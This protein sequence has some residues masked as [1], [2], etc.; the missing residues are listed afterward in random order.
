MKNS[1]KLSLLATVIGSL[2][3][4]GCGDAETTII[5]KDPIAVD[6]HDDGHDDHDHGDDIIIESMG[7]LAVLSVES[8][9]ANIFDLDDNSLLDSFTLTYD[10]SSLKVSADYRYATLVNRNDDNVSF[11]DSGL[12]REDHG[13]HLHDYKQIPMVSSFELN[14]S[15]PTHVVNHDGQMAV[16]YDGDADAGTS[17]SVQVLTDTNIANSSSDLPGIEYTTNMHGVAE[18]RGEH[19]LSTIR[20]DNADSTSTS[21]ILP[22]QVGV[23]HFHDG[24]YELEQTLEVNC[25]N[26]HGA[27]QNHEFVVFGCSDGVLVAEQ[28]GD[29][30]E[31]SK[32]ENID[33]LGELRIGNIYGHENSELFVGVASAHGG[34]EAIFVNLNPEDGEMETIDWQPTTGASPV[35]YS[36]AFGGEHFLILDNLGYLTVLTQ[37]EHD[38]HL[39]FEYAGRIDISEEDVSTMPEGMSFSMTVAQNEH[40][41][42]VADPIAQHVLQI[43][44]EDMEIEGDIELDFAPA[45][46]SWLGIAE[47]GEHDGHDH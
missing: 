28:N 6:D 44:I 25:P 13:E 47:E 30:Y 18:P 15:R 19:L 27:S 26:L 42:Y 24:E 16:F 32:L 45:S 7:R 9:E 33:D 31:A 8:A 23:Y 11:I 4:T 14:G 46:I 3:L 29:E 17:A 38:G 21:L 43:H 41:A 35:S 22:D 39:E 34:G 5:E 1:Y 40:Y 10:S 2:L 36:F 12:W 20:R 37:H